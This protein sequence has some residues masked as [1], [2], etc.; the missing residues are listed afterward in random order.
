MIEAAL[1]FIAVILTM[2]LYEILTGR[3]GV[4]DLMLA[5]SVIVLCTFIVVGL[6]HVIRNRMK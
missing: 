3:Q 6:Y 5:Y 1:A 4:A 2:A